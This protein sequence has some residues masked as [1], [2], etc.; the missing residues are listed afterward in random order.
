MPTGSA[1]FDFYGGD[2]P[3][4]N[5]YANSLARARRR[6]P[7]SALW[8][9]QLVHHDLWDR[10]LPA[11][12]DLVTIE[13]DGRT[14]DAVAQ[15]TKSGH[16]FLFDRVTRRAAASDRGAAGARVRPRR[17]RAPWPTQPLPVRPPPFA[18]QSA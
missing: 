13:R 3:G 14:I 15:I 2:R 1:A 18:R 16:V 10:D 6:A 11:P 17:T 9:H 5:L 7:A 4:A 8:H 12:P